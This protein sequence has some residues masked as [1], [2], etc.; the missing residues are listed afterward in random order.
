MTLNRAPASATILL[1]LESGFG[2]FAHLVDQ[3]SQLIHRVEL[4]SLAPI[5]LVEPLVGGRAEPFEP[6]PVFLL[7]VRSRSPSR[8]TSL[9]LLNRPE[10]TP[11]SM[12]LSKWS[13]RS[14][15]RVGMDGDPPD[16]R[17]T[18]R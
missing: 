6:G 8:T 12:N 7:G 16:S 3:C 5:N 13:V 18:R 2:F 15:L 9:A 4:D 10:V 11:S 17:I 14:T 1:Y